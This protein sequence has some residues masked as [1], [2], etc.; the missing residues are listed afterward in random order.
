[1]KKIITFALIGAA[2]A[3]VVYLLKDNETVRSWTGKAKEAAS[4]GLTSASDGYVDVREKAA[5]AIS[6]IV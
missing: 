3:G 5:I 4:D 1:M 6:E 2:V